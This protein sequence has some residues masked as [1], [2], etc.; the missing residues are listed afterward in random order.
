MICSQV[1]EKKSRRIFLG[2]SLAAILLW[3]PLRGAD[4]QAPAGPIGPPQGADAASA[5]IPAAQP[6]PRPVRKP[7]GGH[8]NLSGSWMMNRDDSDDPGQKI[9]SASE[10]SGGMG[11]PRRGGMGG[12]YGYPGG[13]Y[14][15]GGYPGGGG[16]PGG[17]PGGGVS[18][19]Q[20]QAN[21][22]ALDAVSD[23]SSLTIE[24]TAS[25]AVITSRTGKTL[26]SYSAPDNSST[27]PNSS[28]GTPAGAASPASA[29]TTDS[30]QWQGSEFVTVT[31][32]TTGAKTKTTRT[33][34][35]SSDGSQLNVTTKLEGP[36]FKKPVTFLLVYDAT[37]N[38][39]TGNQ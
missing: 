10:E 16:V 29:K 3:V 19:S 26:T 21:Q 27:A 14:P 7:I 4:A 33:Y 1:E 31:Q 17:N 15:G 30:A 11:A 12:P 6:A 23:L 36:H 9:R 8:P 25:S 24:Q 13:G 32:E 39:T 35:L 2:I 37:N 20:D 28:S 5:E 18:R 34:D 22:D 38:D